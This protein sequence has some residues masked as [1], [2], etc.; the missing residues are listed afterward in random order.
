MLVLEGLIMLKFT[1]L[2][3]LINRL[4]SLFLPCN[5]ASLPNR[6]IYS[7][8][9]LFGIITNFGLPPYYFFSASVIGGAYFFS[10]MFLA[11]VKIRPF[12]AFFFTFGFLYSSL[13]WVGLSV[14]AEGSFFYLYIFVTPFI[15]IILSS[16]SFISFKFLVYTSCHYI[17][18]AFFS[19]FILGLAEYL[20]CLPIWGFCW[21]PFSLIL[22]ESVFT[23]QPFRLFGVYGYSFYIFFMIS[24]VGALFVYY[25]KLRV[26]FYLLSF[27]LLF[28][29]IFIFS[30][31]SL[32]VNSNKI[33]DDQVR[34]LRTNIS[35]NSK[36]SFKHQE[37]SY[38]IDKAYSDF[39]DKIKFVIMPETVSSNIFY[40]TEY[41]YSYLE[42][43][44]K[45]KFK[46][47]T[48]WIFGAIT[49]NDSNY[50]NSIVIYN[51]KTRYLQVYNKN[52]LV[53]FGEY[54]P[55]LSNFKIFSGFASNFG[56]NSSDVQT[57]FLNDTVKPLICYEITFDNYISSNIKY[58]VNV[59]N[60]MWFGNSVG[61]WQHFALAR[62]KAVQ[63]NTNLFRSTNGGISAYIDNLG[64]IINIQKDLKKSFFDT[65]IYLR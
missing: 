45:D 18:F 2:I 40:S 30:F 42:N 56:F 35:V 17:I 33:T 36:T 10:V 29:F 1:T 26:T 3:S 5:I 53:P 7:F 47:N 50:Y 6:Y 8:S 20:R 44:F 43:A 27:S 34:I 48:N 28:S 39:D 65:F 32:K 12:I 24:F 49:S 19:C 46:Y 15:V 38:W 51:P 57:T 25:D 61:P 4:F 9:L 16:I 63:Y 62:I 58:I 41:M 59:S 37:L 13:L 55:I 31:F 60:D 21:N 22:S 54:L 23:L 52:R 11:D 64:N 14:V